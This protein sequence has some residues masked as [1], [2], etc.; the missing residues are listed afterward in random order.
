MWLSALYY[1]KVYAIFWILITGLALTSNQNP[2]LLTTY[3]YQ[4][5]T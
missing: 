3:N 1:N 5:F 4:T 2:I